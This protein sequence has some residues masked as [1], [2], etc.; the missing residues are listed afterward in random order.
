[1]NKQVEQ[2]VKLH[3]ASNTV[4]FIIVGRGI[5]FAGSIVIFLTYSPASPAAERLTS[6]CLAK[7]WCHAPLSREGEHSSTR[8]NKGAEGRSNHGRVGP[9]QRRG[10]MQNMWCIQNVT[11]A[12][13]CAT[14]AAL[15]FHV[16]G[17]GRGLRGGRDTGKK[18]NRET[19]T[20]LTVSADGAKCGKAKA[21]RHPSAWT[22][23]CDFRRIQ[24]FLRNFPL[25]CFQC[26]SQSPSL[27]I[28]SVKKQPLKVAAQWSHWSKQPPLL[29]GLNKYN[30]DWLWKKRQIEIDES[31]AQWVESIMV[32]ISIK[33]HQF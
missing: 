29:E 10:T 18:K 25:K 28:M 16:G 3:F 8:D 20:K 6:T 4:F 30:T 2:Q 23:C 32:L 5:R 13:Q 21:P 7:L 14:S 19:E 17:K 1:M 26:F 9:S 27:K 12:A 15:R 24:V 31:S 22:L 11:R 33:S